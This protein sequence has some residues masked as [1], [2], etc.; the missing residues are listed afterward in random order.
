MVVDFDSELDNY[1]T[2]FTWNEL[3]RASSVVFTNLHVVVVTRKFCTVNTTIIEN[4][5]A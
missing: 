3:L 2:N 4:M 5:L 1:L